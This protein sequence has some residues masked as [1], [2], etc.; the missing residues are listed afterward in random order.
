L[1]GFANPQLLTHPFAFMAQVSCRVPSEV[2]KALE[3]AANEQGVFKAD[4]VRRAIVHYIKQNPDDF[5][6]Y[7]K[8]RSQSPSNEDGRIYDPMHDI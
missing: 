8:D 1:N 6:V 3:A 4:I 7:S 5:E 2:D